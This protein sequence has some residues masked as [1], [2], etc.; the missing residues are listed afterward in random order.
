MTVLRRQLEIE[1]KFSVPW[2]AISHGSVEKLN[3]TVENVLRRLL[4]G[5][6][7]RTG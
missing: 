5:R 3:A 1:G 4:N 7:I 6:L 2:H